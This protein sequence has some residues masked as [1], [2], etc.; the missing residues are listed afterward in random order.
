MVRE[1]LTNLF[2]LYMKFVKL[3]YILAVI[4]VGKLWCILATIT[5]SKKFFPNP[6]RPDSSGMNAQA[7][8][9]LEYFS[10]VVQCLRLYS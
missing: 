5:G 8:A 2:G 6:S 4:K 9:I 7:L 1:N 3:R 10:K